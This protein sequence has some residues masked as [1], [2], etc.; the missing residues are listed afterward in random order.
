MSDKASFEMLMSLGQKKKLLKS[1]GQKKTKFS[2]R[3][4]HTIFKNGTAD[5]LRAGGA[6]CESCD[7]NNPYGPGCRSGEQ[8]PA[9]SA[10]A[11]CGQFSPVVSAAL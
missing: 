5:V 11:P 8:V 1:L 4:L 7:R 6:G 10:T 9:H 3:I 2:N